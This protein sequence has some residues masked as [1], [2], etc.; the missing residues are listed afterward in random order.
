MRMSFIDMV[1]LA[2]PVAPMM[3]NL[4]GYLSAAS[5]FSQEV[6]KHICL[7]VRHDLSG[8][9]Q[10]LEEVS[11]S[12]EHQQIL[13][14]RFSWLLAEYNLLNSVDGARSRPRM[15]GFLVSC[16]AWSSYVDVWHGL[17][18]W[19]PATEEFKKAMAH[20]IRSRK[21]D[22]SIP[23]DTP[24]W[25]REMYERLIK[26]DRREDWTDLLEDTGR[27]MVPNVDIAFAQA[28]SG[29]V[30]IAPDVLARV[31]AL[32]ETWLEI[33]II[34]N[35]IK[36]TRAFF[37][38]A[39][40]GTSRA[41][42][43]ALS[44]VDNVSLITDDAVAEL[45]TKAADDLDVWSAILHAFNKY[46]VRY[47]WL[48]KGLGRVLAVVSSEHLKRYV[49]S[50]D[51]IHSPDC[52]EQITVCLKTL[53]A[54]ASYETRVV[55]WH[56]A[57]DRWVQWQVGLTNDNSGSGRQTSIVD[58]AVIGW[59]VEGCHDKQLREWLEQMNLELQR[60]PQRWFSS[61]EE[62]DI[63][64]DKLR[65]RYRMYHAALRGRHSGSWSA[66]LSTEIPNAISLPYWQSRWGEN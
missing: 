14:G 52:A 22:V 60:L 4:E 55:C 3:P 23:E 58:Y 49:D 50:L 5:D 40:S 51:I 59:L 13:T 61:K 7:M 39:Q 18:E 32:T 34:L 25:E 47:P 36:G 11:E 33:A 43:T 38:A 10:L 63:A 45:L 27:F 66:E 62:F 37:I 44:S 31:V 28:V 29:L 12:T 35:Q 19:E 57:Y 30:V 46:P 54:N 21:V 16:M 15:N 65:L 8:S 56:F 6:L 41:I 9:L 2:K 42:F 1:A 64:L 26:A 17:I 24:V 48:Q 20:E 53:Q